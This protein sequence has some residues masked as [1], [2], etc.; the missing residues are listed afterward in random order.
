MVLNDRPLTNQKD[1]LSSSLNLTD[2][3]FYICLVDEKKQRKQSHFDF[4]PFIWPAMQA[5]I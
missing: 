2:Q 1:G 4:P 3:D 5:S